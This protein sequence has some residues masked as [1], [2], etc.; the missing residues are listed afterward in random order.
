[1]LT[2]GEEPAA[3]DWALS[4][5][6]EPVDKQR[7]DMN[8]LLSGQT[9]SVL[10]APGT[11]GHVLLAAAQGRLCTVWADQM[12]GPAVKLA[13]VELMGMLSAKGARIQAQ[14]DRN[15]E[16]AGAWRHQ[17][18]W[19]YRAVGVTQELGVG[20]VTTLSDAPGTQALHIEPLQATPAF[21]PDG[22]SIR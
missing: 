4:Q 6:F 5:G 1:M 10:A 11:Q 13:M 18:Q 15:I 21:A 16:R 8:G 20:A 14:P 19:R 22:L 2:G 7:G 3:V 9:G 12:S 17:M